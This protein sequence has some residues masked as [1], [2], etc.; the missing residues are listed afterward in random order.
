MQDIVNHAILHNFVYPYKYL[1][2]GRKRYV[3]SAAKLLLL[4]LYVINYCGFF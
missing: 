4:W 2:E 1:K 3:G